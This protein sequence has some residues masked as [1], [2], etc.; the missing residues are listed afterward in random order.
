MADLP[1]NHYLVGSSCPS[2]I[3]LARDPEVV[4]AVWEPQEFAIAVARIQI[5][6]TWSLRYC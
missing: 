4:L 5:V 1:A 6:P 3:S 2:Q